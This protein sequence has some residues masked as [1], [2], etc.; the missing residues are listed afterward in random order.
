MQT[1]G[2]LRADSKNAH[3]QILTSKDEEG[4][5][6]CVIPL[7]RRYLRA[8]LRIVA[9]RAACHRA[10]DQGGFYYDIHMEHKLKPEDLEKIEKKMLEII[11]R[12]SLLSARCGIRMPRSN[13]SKISVIFIRRISSSAPR[14]ASV[15][16]RQDEF[17]DLC[18]GPH[19]VRPAG[20]QG[21]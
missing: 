16:Y 1:A 12:T 21:V 8:A 7:P 15:I 19:I 2:Y 13:I 18:Y 9:G 17:M 4:W 11:D 5:I 14:S 3:L 6:S 20:F 10:D